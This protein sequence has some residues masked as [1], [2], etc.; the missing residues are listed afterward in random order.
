MSLGIA[1]PEF[2]FGLVL[3]A[4]LAAMAAGGRAAASGGR[5][6]GAGRAAALAAVYVVLYAVFVAPAPATLLLCSILGGL[7]AHELLAGFAAGKGPRFSATF[8]VLALGIALLTPWL[9]PAARATGLAEPAL[10]LGGALLLA[11]AALAGPSRARALAC[12]LTIAAAV[13]ALATFGR[14]RALPDGG[15]LC[16][17]AF[18]LIN[19]A[20]TAAYF[21]GRLFGRHKLAPAISPGKTVEGALGSLVVTAAIA[22]GFNA[23]LELGF[24]RAEVLVAAVLLNVLG[25]AGDLLESLLKRRL[26]L[27]DFGTLLGGH[28]GIL[29]RFDSC[30]L[31]VPA[32]LLWVQAIR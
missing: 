32:F 10:A 23:V 4:L 15:R 8:R 3:C 28:G 22:F 26:G 19:V 30:L 6:L 9:P 31:A 18:F 17:F 21:C 12:T 7:A 1:A 2:R 25:Q 14:L 20:D 29:D 24:T 16:L 27:K 13:A 5:S 11:G